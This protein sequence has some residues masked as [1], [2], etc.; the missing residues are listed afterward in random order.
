M[1]HYVRRRRLTQP[2]SKYLDLRDFR[3]QLDQFSKEARFPDQEEFLNAVRGGYTIPEAV[4]LT[5]DDGL[6]DHFE[7]VFPELK[8][9]GLWGI[10][11]IP[12]GPFVMNKALDVHRVHYLLGRFG[13]EKVF[14]MLRP[15]IV[16]DINSKEFDY[17]L[18]SNTYQQQNKEQSARVVKQ[19]LNYSLTKD[20]RV[21]VL[22]EM[23][24][25]YVEHERQLV[26]QIYMTPKMV[27]ALHDHG[28]LIG[29][30]SMSH[31]VFSSLSIEE[32][33]NEIVESFR[34][35]QEITGGL[36]IRSFCYPYGLPATYTSETEAL[37]TKVHCDFSFAVDFRN[38]E[39]IDLIKRPQALPRYDCNQ[40]II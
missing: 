32:Q 22:D 33:E 6:L 9:R 7:F 30:H 11:Y 17:A 29:S 37:L 27:R 4:I 26:D 25:S 31:P 12:T 35:L 23:I 16:N 40:F 1:Y 15:L 28:M 10:F 3:S 8:Q 19:I 14:D 39:A 13:G 20:R 2:Y 21:A 24:G 36:N 5:F 34:V 38:I 18:D